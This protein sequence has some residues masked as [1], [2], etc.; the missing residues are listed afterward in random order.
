[1]FYRERSRAVV[2]IVGDKRIDLVTSADLRLVLAQCSPGTAPHNFSFLRRLFRFLIAEE[3]LERNPMAKLQPPKVESKVVDPLSTEEMVRC[4]KAA[5]AQGGLLGVRDAAIFAT[6]GR[7]GSAPRGAVPAA[8]RGRAPR[9][10][11]HADPWQG[12]Q[13]APGAHSGDLRVLMSQYLYRRKDSRAEGSLRPFLPRPQRDAHGPQQPHHAHGPP[14]PPRRRPSA[15]SP[16][17]PHLRYRFMS[18]DGSDVLHLKEICGWT[19]LA[20][21]QR[22]AKPTM[23][24]MI[25]MV[26][27]FSPVNELR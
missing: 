6:L 4:F 23:A 3:V 25:R 11:H 22:Y 18:H 8:R 27:S 19:T 16:A 12:P 5:K 7:H 2:K 24:K 10:G 26:D 14:G 17:A 9:R 1:M 21:A 15:P 13:T 20:M